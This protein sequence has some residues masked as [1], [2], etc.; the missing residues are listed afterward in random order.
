MKA[1]TKLRGCGDCICGA[2][3][4]N[5]QHHQFCISEIPGPYEQLAPYWW[6][7]WNERV[8]GRPSRTHEGGKG[9]RESYKMGYLM[10]QELQE[11]AKS[12][13]TLSPPQLHRA[14]RPK[15]APQAA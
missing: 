14:P 8:Q 9:P 3:L 1:T 15:Q 7:G 2:D 11:R 5:R 4:D 13:V 12:N 10:A 6:L